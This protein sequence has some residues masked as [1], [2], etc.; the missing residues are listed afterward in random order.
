MFKSPL[1][2]FLM[3]VSKVI[4]RR[5]CTQDKERFD[6]NSNVL[7]TDTNTQP[8]AWSSILNIPLAHDGQ[9]SPRFLRCLLKF[10]TGMSEVS[11]GK[12]R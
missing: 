10:E 4:Y 12:C 9:R 2:A 7:Y 3:K 8:C 6:V 11:L 5:G 1:R